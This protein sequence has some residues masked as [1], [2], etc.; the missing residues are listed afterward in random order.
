MQ[1]ALPPGGSERQAFPGDGASIVVMGPVSRSAAVALYP[2][3]ASL[4]RTPPD[5]IIAEA[6]EFGEAEEADEEDEDE[7]AA[8]SQTNTSPRGCRPLPFTS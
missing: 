8:R 5:A 4:P 2:T 7:E 6:A 1:A 3:G